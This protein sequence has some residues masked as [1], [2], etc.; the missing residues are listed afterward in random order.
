MS[1]GSHRWKA[2][3]GRSRAVIALASAGVVGAVT[4]G[5]SSAATET[6]APRKTADHR[7]ATAEASRIPQTA[8]G[9]PKRFGTGAV[10]SKENGRTTALGKALKPRLSALAPGALVGAKPSTARAALPESVDLSK[11]APAPGNQ[12]Q[13]GSCAAWAV[14]YTAYG[15]LEREQKISGG[16][17]APMFTYAQVVKGQQRGTSLADHFR[18]AM[19]QGVDAKSHYW[20]GDFDYTTQPTAD[21]TRNAAKWKLSGYTPLHTG[22]RLQAEVK[23]ALAKGLPVTVAMPVH[24]SFFAVTPRTAASYRYSLT[25]GDPMAGGHAMAIVG[26]N[27][28]GVRVENSWGSGWGDHGFINLS[29]KF[30]T[31]QAWEANAVGKLIKR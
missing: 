20:Q 29:W 23:A 30:L 17:Q 6:T 5:V 22:S 2:M 19:K 28:K 15:L 24:N 21:Q 26:Y 7:A 10:P 4:V 9:K 25:A 1:H 11:Y 31:D 14:D 18:I 27:S 8:A 13:V 16:P 3:G 12:G